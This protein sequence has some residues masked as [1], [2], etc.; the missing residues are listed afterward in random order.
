MTSLGEYSLAYFRP[1]DINDVKLVPFEFLRLRIQQPL[2]AQ[3]GVHGEYPENPIAAACCEVGP[4][5]A[6]LSDSGLGGFIECGSAHVNCCIKILY[7]VEVPE[8]IFLLI[9]L[10][11]PL[12]FAG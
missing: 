1:G 5:V 7:A 10:H 8:V 3:L 9:L 6:E 12:V 2:G 11:N 4:L